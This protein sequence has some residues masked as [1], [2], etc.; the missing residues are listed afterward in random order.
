[1][2]VLEAI[3]EEDFPGFSYGF[4][5]GRSQHDALDALSVGIDRKKVNWVLDADIRGFFDTID[6]GW[7]L[8]F[9]EH[10][11][12]DLRVLRLIR[13]W[14]RAGV[15]EDGTWSATKVGTPQGAVVSPLLANV[16]LHYVLDLWAE[17]WRRKYAKGDVIIVRYADDFVMGFQQRTEA[18]R[19][20]KELG[21]RMQKFGL[22]LHPDKTRLIEFGRYAAE[23]RAERGAGKPETFNFLGFTH[24]CGKTRRGRFAVRRETMAKRLRAKLQAVKADLQ[25]RRHEPVAQQGAWLGAVVQGYFNYHAIPGN[26]EA[27]QQ[28]RTQVEWLWHRSL[29]RRS[30]KAHLTWGRFVATAD[31]WLPK[32][33][34]RHPY[35][36]VRF[37]AKHPR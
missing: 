11:I 15:S 22:E 32:P 1:M 37:D 2:T 7:L 4:R 28:F 3:Y 27:L 17:Y 9:L 20:L 35:P 13:K 5:P 21:E 36:E 14:L 18:E 12:A 19:F 29:Q 25:R 10:R 23:R 34:I 8:R 26:Y 16:Y 6:H 33:C 30:Q 31:R 24:R